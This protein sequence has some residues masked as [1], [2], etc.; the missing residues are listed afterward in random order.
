MTK[1]PLMC[2]ALLVTSTLTL[3]G[4]SSSAQSPVDAP[5]RTPDLSEQLQAWAT[6]VCRS[7]DALSRQVTGIAD[8]LDV[9][10]GAGL[11]QLPEL[12]QQVTANIDE[13]QRRLDE[14][15]EA[16]AAAPAQSPRAVEFAAELDALIEN[17]RSSGQEAVDLLAEATSADNFLSAG[18]AAAGA[19]AAA[20][21]A[22]NDAST[23]LDLLDRTR[24]EGAGEV[25]EAFSTAQGCK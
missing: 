14:V 13:V 11:D 23:A 21:S 9:D 4:C 15:Q 1:W 3:S 10:L 17:A 24:S 6:D 16:L 12:Q 8:G 25:G 5:T 2:C 22:Y 20:Q 18:L 19:A 7:S